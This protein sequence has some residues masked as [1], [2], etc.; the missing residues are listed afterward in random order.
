MISQA[1]L[2]QALEGVLVPGA[3]RDLVKMNLVRGLTVAGDKVSVVIAAAALPPPT[4]DWLKAKVEEA[5][6]KERGVKSVEVK[7][8]DAKPAEVNAVGKVIAVM[9]GK[10]GVG[11]SLVSGLLAVSLQQA[12]YEVGILDADITGPSIPRMFG[13]SG[14]K[15]AGNED[16][17]IPVLSANG[18]EV[19]SINLMLENEDEPVIWR[20]PV[21]AKV[22]QQFWQ[23][24]LWGKLDYL[25]VDL[26]PGTSDAPLTVMQSLPVAGA[27]VVLSPQ[28]LAAMVV[29]K[30]VKMAK[31]L[32][33]PV[34]GVVENLAYFEIPGS[35][36]RVELFGPSRLAEMA[37]AAE[38]KLTVQLPVDTRLAALC[39]NGKIEQYRSKDFDTFAKAL[40]AA[41]VKPKVQ[42][43]GG[44]QT[45][46]TFP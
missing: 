4:H 21:V 40:A 1:K 26:P 27:V 30:A 14:V 45:K 24:T 10:G 32:S 9:S 31:K 41:P 43:P 19:M 20:G 33:I 28:Q 5:L 38:T 17:L 36:K 22:I 6:M 3:R 7:V 2:T 8:I 11:K 37:E 34:L 29:R 25:I 23:D 42:M 15:P 35:K 18:I 44:Q 16:S 39:D 46:T 12:G 13:L